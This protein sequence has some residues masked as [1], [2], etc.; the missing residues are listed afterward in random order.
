MKTQLFGVTPSDPVTYAIAIPVI[1][2]AAL[3]ACWIPARRA[4]RISPLEALRN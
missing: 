2:L 3:L 1:G 4:T